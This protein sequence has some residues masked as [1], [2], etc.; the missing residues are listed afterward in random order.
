ME[1]DDKFAKIAY[2]VAQ[3]AGT[4]LSIL[5]HTL[6]FLTAFGFVLFGFDFDRVLLVVTTVVSLEAIYLSLFLQIAVNMQT[7][8]INTQTKHI[9]DVKEEIEDIQE[10]IEDQTKHIE[11]VKEEIE[12]IQE[13]IEDLN[14][15]N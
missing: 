10:N 6:F 13:N 12:D 8:N 15:E 4:P 9:E 2:K 7:K 1:Q 5:I 11:D 14:E 3:A